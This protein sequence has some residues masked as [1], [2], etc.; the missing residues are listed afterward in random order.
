MFISD[1]G[2]NR[3]KLLGDDLTGHTVICGVLSIK[4]IILFR[5]IFLGVH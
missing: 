1:T 2:L 5:N 4:E 3:G